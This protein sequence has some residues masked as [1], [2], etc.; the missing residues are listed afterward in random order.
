M[1]GEQALP[2]V[3][4]GLR[5][6]GRRI[7]VVGAGRIAA[8]KAAAYANQGAVLTVVAPRSSPEMEQVAVRIRVRREFERTDLDG[9]W[10]VVTATG[11]PAVDRTVFEEAERRRIWC[12]AADDPEHCSV[13]LPAVAR[14]GDITI[15][16]STG[17][18][19]PAVASWLRRQVESLLDADTIEIARRSASVRTTVRALGL[20]T[21]V[22]GWDRV[23]EHA[24]PLVAAGRGDEFESQLLTAVVGGRT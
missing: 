1:S 15:S 18:T 3:P 22:D 9:A 13:I 14:A 23:L 5:V 21:E 12:N 16:I 17:G 4:V 19:S 2:I 7:V 10:L 8:R 20:S 11:L 24:R 6:A